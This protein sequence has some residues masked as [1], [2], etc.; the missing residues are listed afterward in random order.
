M[1]YRRIDSTDQDDFWCGVTIHESL[2]LTPKYDN[3]GKWFEKNCEGYW[4]I[5]LSRPAYPD[6][7]VIL[8]TEEEDK[9]KFILK[10]V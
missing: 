10:W 3:F 8:F 5:G 2:L 4:S 9:V 1:T 6:R 7:N